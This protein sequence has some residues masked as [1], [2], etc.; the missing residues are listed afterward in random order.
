MP[1][2][3]DVANDILSRLD[4]IN[5]HTAA[6][7]T[8]TAQIHTDTQAIRNTALQIQSEI[9]VL[10]NN[11]T[12]GLAALI[13]IELA[14]LQRLDQIIAQNSAVLCNLEHAND[15]LCRQLHRLDTI[16]DL[17]KSEVRLTGHLDAVIELAYGEEA[18]QV[19]RRNELQERLDQCCPPKLPPPE[20]CPEACPRPKWE[21]RKPD[22]SGF[23]PVLLPVPNRDGQVG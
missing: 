12:T 5:G 7:E 22:V 15:L 4:S 14:G 8:S 10:N 23:S 2:I 21:P 19:E 17:Q 18:M 13:Q 3:S 1:S 6:T 20:L 9:A 16:V 11:V